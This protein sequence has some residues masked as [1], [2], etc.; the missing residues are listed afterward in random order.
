MGRILRG[1]TR[2]IG[3]IVGASQP[4]FYPEAV[5]GV[6]VP[7]PEDPPA[8]TAVRLVGPGGEELITEESLPSSGR[9]GIRRPPSKARRKKN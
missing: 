7:E 3:N 6:P 8:W 4:G 9:S 2:F 1:L 5:R